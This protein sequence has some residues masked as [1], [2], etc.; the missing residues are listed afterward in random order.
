MVTYGEVVSVVQLVRVV[1]PDTKCV[2][3]GC[4][5]LA[6]F[7][8][9][10]EHNQY[11]EQASWHICAPCTHASGCEEHNGAVA[12]MTYWAGPNDPA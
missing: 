12:D 8:W 11:N 1:N 7:A 5:N 2:N 3:D 10:A 9:L 4:N 6:E